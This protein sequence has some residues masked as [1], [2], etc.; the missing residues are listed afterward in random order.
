MDESTALVIKPARLQR[1]DKHGLR[2]NQ[3]RALI[4]LGM[5]AGWVEAA[6]EAGVEV[7]TLRG[8]TQLDPAFITEYQ[9]LLTG[10]LDEVKGR[11][12]SLLPAVGEVMADALNSDKPLDV[13]VVCPDC[14]ARFST[15]VEGPNWN[16]RLRVAENILKQHGQLGTNV[17]IEGK[18]E[19]EH[20]LELSTD[21]RIAVQLLKRGMHDQVPPSVFESLKQRGI[22]EGEYRVLDAPTPEPPEE[23]QA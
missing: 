13:D 2:L 16:I 7:C 9:N 10:L 21:D 1:R 18:I 6:K 19:H 8:W 20:T 4:A 12:S 14:G 17:H 11:M 5:G 15:V 22:I 3:K 23:A